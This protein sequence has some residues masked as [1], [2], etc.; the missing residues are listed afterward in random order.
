[1]LMFSC[2]QV[3]GGSLCDSGHSA[4][5]SILTQS[6]PALVDSI[7]TQ[8]ITSLCEEYVPHIQL[9]VIDNT[10]IS[11]QGTSDA[12]G[13]LSVL[14]KTMSSGSGVNT[15]LEAQ[16]I[17]LDVPFYHIADIT[18]SEADAANAERNDQSDPYAEGRDWN[19]IPVPPNH[20][21][22]TPAHSE[23]SNDTCSENGRSLEGVYEVNW[24]AVTVLTIER[25]GTNSTYTGSE[26]SDNEAKSFS[27]SNL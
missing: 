23:A 26:V 25:P 21:L 1:M 10:V 5:E 7:F 12:S 9:N 19:A 2:I 22:H 17:L 18:A 13:T 20:Q 27:E 3:A 8:A 6:V 14:N 24:D 15:N 11:N 16:Y 4:G